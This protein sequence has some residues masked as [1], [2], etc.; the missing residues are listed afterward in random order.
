MAKGAASIHPGYP[1]SL[2]ARDMA[3]FGL[4]YL[5][6]GA[7]R[8]K[9]IVPSNLGAAQRDFSFTRRQHGRLT[10][11]CGGWPWPA[12]YFPASRWTMAHLRRRELAA[13]ISW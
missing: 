1:M 11:I 8:D 7:W 4:L 12:N 13:T 9:Q 5:R 2:T 3:R 10:V 6:E